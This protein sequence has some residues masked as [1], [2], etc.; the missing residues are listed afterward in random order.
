MK[1]VMHHDNSAFAPSRLLGRLRTRAGWPPPLL[2]LGGALLLVASALLFAV[3]GPG[4]APVISAQSNSAPSF[5]SSGNSTAHTFPE[6]SGPVIELG[7]YTV[8]DPD[9]DT[10]TLTLAGADHAKFAIDEPWPAGTHT[11]FGLELNA[12]PDYENPDDADQNRVYE[13][14]LRATDAGGSNQTAELDITV[15]VTDVDETPPVITGAAAVNFPE[16]STDSV[17]QYTAKDPDTDALT[18]TLAGDDA[19]KFAMG[20]PT[21]SENSTTFGLSLNATPD[22]ENPDDADEDGVYEVTLQAAEADGTG[23]TGELDVRVTVTNVDEAP[24]ITGLATV[25]VPE[26]PVADVGRYTV[27]DPEGQPPKL[28]LEGPNA[29][30][31]RFID[32]TL[33]FKTAPTHGATNSHSVTIKASDGTFTTTLGVAVT[34][35]DMPEITGLGVTSQRGS[36]AVAVDWDDSTGAVD[37]LVRWGPPGPHQVPNQGVRSASSDATITVRD[38]GKWVV[39]A[40]A[41]NAS[42]CG[43]V[44]TKEVTV[45]GGAFCNRTPTVRN[46]IMDEIPY[47]ADCSAV[48]AQQ[49]AAITGPVD[50]GGTFIT[51]LKAGDFAGLTGLTGLSLSHNRFT[52]LPAGLFDGLGE[53]LTLRLNNNRVEALPADL[54]DDLVKLEVLHLNQN[55]LAEL[56]AGLFDDLTKLEALHLNRNEL[57]ELPAD[58]FDNLTKLKGLHLDR[59]RLTAVPADLIDNKASLHTLNLAHNDLSSIPTGLLVGRPNLRTLTLD[60]NPPLNLPAGALQHLT[61]ITTLT[62]PELADPGLCGRPEA[63]RTAVLSRLSTISDCKLVTYGDV[64]SV[65]D[66]IPAPPVCDRTPVVRDAIVNAVH[67][68]T[69]C[70]DVTSDHL[71]GITGTF[72]LDDNDLTA[73]KMGDLDGLT[74]ITGLALH[75][76]A[77]MILPFGFFKD[78]GAVTRV[79]LN[80]NLL[81]TLDRTTFH[82]MDALTRVDLNHN[83][84]KNIPAGMFH[85]HTQLQEIN[86][87]NNGAFGRLRSDSFAGLTALHTL[88]LHGALNLKFEP[89]IF[90]DLTSLRTLQLDDRI[91]MRVCGKPATERTAILGTVPGYDDCKLVTHA[92]LGPYA[93]QYIEENIITPVQETHPWVREAWFDVPVIIDVRPP[94]WN[95]WAGAYLYSNPGEVW[96]YGRNSYKGKEVLFHELGHHYTLH[97]RI[98]ADNPDGKLSMLAMWLFYTDFKRRHGF[99]N[100]P[101]EYI[102]GEMSDWVTRG[103]AADWERPE[104]KGVIS[105]A[106]S[107]R[108]PWWFLEK[109]TTDRTM[110]TVNLPMLWN[111]MRNLGNAKYQLDGLFGGFCSPKEGLAALRNPNMHNPWVDGG[112]LNRRPQHLSATAAG[113]GRLTVSWQAPLWSDGPAINAYVVQWKSG[114]DA[115]FSQ[116]TVT[117]LSHTISNLTS[118]TEYTVRV[119]AI[120]NQ[121]STDFIDNHGHSRVA[122]TT[123]NAG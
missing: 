123:G 86:L 36:L 104:F 34:V 22:F 91:D 70:A 60:S 89:E 25:S 28:T 1:P 31:F 38:Y 49:L 19:G 14:T 83:N 67:G 23:V 7:T 93:H 45:D 113:P 30:S 63:V 4:S 66:D 39:Q 20:E 27:R 81:H 11:I 72:A 102:V 80:H 35:V 46:A 59:N 94:D 21:T 47:V 69:A 75:E 24:V 88:R 109:Y 2:L 15:T 54:F 96:L 98:H 105:A 95:Q 58:P 87:H 111:H 99:P 121:G 62:L 116:T 97:D 73:L 106:S 85:G 103:E 114:D 77:L 6:N 51:E 76:N 117:T 78:L 122:E 9:G 50:L 18:L 108:I 79:Q 61:G 55:K 68:I 100:N 12:T 74:G 53:L 13:V 82:G 112:C 41:C 5:P 10:I 118:G 101:T 90:N 40:Q 71:A 16:G 115:E 37:Y 56:P 110:G 32:E 8:V 3:S 119:A 42:G 44:A 120:N 26:G 52:E 33:I 84:L 43:P 107:E 17:G 65:L 29:A 92:D 64:T 57:T 48:T